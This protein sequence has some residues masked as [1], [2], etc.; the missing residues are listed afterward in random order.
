MTVDP[1]LSRTEH[2][3]HSHRHL[4]DMFDAGERADE[5][6]AVDAI[7]VPT[8]RHPRWLTHA[9]HLAGAISCPLVSLHSRWS[10]AGQAAGWMPHGVDFL[11]IDIGDPD[12]LNLPDFATTALLRGTPFPRTTDL[13][14]KRNTALVLARLMGWRRIVF[15]DDDIEVGSPQDVTRAAE[16]L[17]SYD[18]VGMQIDGYPDNSVVCHAHRE[19]GGYQD[20]FVGGGALAVETTRSPSFFP[21][22]YNEDWF[23]LL[24]DASLRRLAV[25]GKVKQRPFDPF[26]QQVRARDQEL[27][28]VLAEGVYWLLDKDPRQGW[29]PATDPAHWICFLDARDRFIADILDRVRQLPVDDRRRRAMESSLLAARGRLHRIEPDFCVAYLKAWLED[30]RR[31]GDHLNAIPQL[32][33]HPQDVMKW[34]IKDGATTLRWWKSLRFAY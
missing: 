31:W 26:D 6:G 1:V 10:D 17:D 29:K 18:A 30:R 32:G 34:L 25:T 27:G 33:P 28:D 15:L 8:I 4:V 24:T 7:V 20:S 16:L 2:H 13:S 5:A 23:Y 19:T 14:A 9:I 11:A 21:N 12:G 3:H 22:V